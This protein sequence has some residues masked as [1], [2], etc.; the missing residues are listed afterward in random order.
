LTW[1]LATGKLKFFAS[2]E[3]VTITADK[4]SYSIGDTIK[5]SINVDPLSK[6]Y[7]IFDINVDWNASKNLVT[8]TKVVEEPGFIS[9]VPSTSIDKLNADAKITPLRFVNLSG[10]DKP[11]V[12]GTLEFRA[13]AGG[14]FTLN[15]SEAKIKAQNDSAY[16]PISSSGISVTIIEATPTPVTETAA[17]TTTTETILPGTP[18]E[19]PAETATAAGLTPTFTI[20]QRADIWG[21]H[22]MPDGILDTFDLSRLRALIKQCQQDPNCPKSK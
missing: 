4:D 13:E 6:T 5:L 21:P 12:V 1:A 11:G 3:Q 18:R 9:N 22:Q 20:Y 16:T 10:T 7:N 8:L 17:A 15:V 19:T 14:T 2:A